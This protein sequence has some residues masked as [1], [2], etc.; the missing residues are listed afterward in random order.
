MLKQ[1]PEAYVHI[2]ALIRKILRTEELKNSDKFFVPAVPC[3]AVDPHVGDSVAKISEV[4]R[5]DEIFPPNCERINTLQEP[6]KGKISEK[7]LY[8]LER[9]LIKGAGAERIDDG[10]DHLHRL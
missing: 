3:V 5:L 8:F 6:G 2:A 1:R 10:Q 9:L 4:L 7:I